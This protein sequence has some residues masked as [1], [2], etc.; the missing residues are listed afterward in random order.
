MSL[1]IYDFNPT[2]VKA[3]TRVAY[4]RDNIL[5]QISH[6]FKEYKLYSTQGTRKEATASHW[7]TVYLVTTCIQATYWYHMHT[8]GRS[9]AQLRVKL[10]PNWG[11]N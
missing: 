8:S 10:Q 1:E 5:G 4:I 11:P 2:R 7:A 9:C 6:G 3:Q